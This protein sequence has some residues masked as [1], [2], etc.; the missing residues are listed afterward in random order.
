MQTLECKILVR[1][2]FQGQKWVEWTTNKMDCKTAHQNRMWQWP[3]TIKNRTLR[4]KFLWIQITLQNNVFFNFHQR[5]N[6]CFEK[7]LRNVFL[8]YQIY[9]RI[10]SICDVL[11][12]HCA[13]AHTSDKFYWPLVSWDHI[14]KTSFPSYVI[15]RPIKRKCLSLASLSNLVICNTP[16]YW[17]HS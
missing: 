8:I 4:D 1:S 11:F 6:N 16:A 7:T 5:K 17:A 14:H 3:L 10:F 9:E 15:N 2:V 12:I 13:V